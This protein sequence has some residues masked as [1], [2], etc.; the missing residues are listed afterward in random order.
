MAVQMFPVFTRRRVPTVAVCCYANHLQTDFYSVIALRRLCRKA[1][2]NLGK[3]NLALQLFSNGIRT[4][5]R[6]TEGLYTKCGFMADHD[7]QRLKGPDTEEVSVQQ[8]ES[9]SRGSGKSL[10]FRSGSI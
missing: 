2:T 7:G 1:E 10:G 5:D 8:V 9:R 6:S 4:W 3:S